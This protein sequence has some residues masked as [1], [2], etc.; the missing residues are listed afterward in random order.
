MDG[1]S[2]AA[3]ATCSEKVIP[4]QKYNG[5]NALG[6]QSQEVRS[7]KIEWDPDKHLIYPIEPKAILPRDNLQNTM[8]SAYKNQI[9]CD[10]SLVTDDG[11]VK[12]HSVILFTYGGEVI[13]KILTVNMK[14]SLEKTICFNSFSLNTVKAFVDYIYLGE[15]A[16]KPESFLEKDINLCELFEMAHIYQ[17]QPLI[18]C[19]TNLFSLFSSLDDINQIESLADHYEN[20]HLKALYEHL[21]MKLSLS[22]RTCGTS[23]KLNG[24]ITVAKP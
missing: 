18:D 5:G 14:E 1:L 7:L 2:K 12:I 20:A 21:S 6:I 24:F 17:I 23:T 19:C 11:I 8:Y 22:S 16:F 10:Y 4:N 15:K 9:M 13:Q 3:G